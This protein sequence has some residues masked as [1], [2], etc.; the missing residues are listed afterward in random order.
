MIY[1]NLDERWAVLVVSGIMTTLAAARR[2]LWCH[3]LTGQCNHAA[4]PPTMFG[5]PP[6]T[7]AEERAIDELLRSA[8]GDAHPGFEHLRPTVHRARRQQH[9]DD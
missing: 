1:I 5:P 3:A 8:E 2:C 4:C 9:A 7:D 6:R